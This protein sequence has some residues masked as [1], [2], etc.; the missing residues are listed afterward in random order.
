[1]KLTKL[2]VFCI[3]SLLFSVIAVAQDV[4]VNGIIKDESGMPV[5]GATILL[6]GTTKSTASDFD[7]K[8]QIQVPSNGSLIVTFIGYATVTEAINGR[9]KLTIQLKP[10]SQSLNEVVVVGYGTQK[11]SV[12]TGA[13]SSVKASDLE[14]LPITRVE[15]SLQGRVSGVTIAANAGQPGSSSTIRVRGI[16]SF[17]NNEPLWVVDG[18]IVDSGGIGYLN[19]SDIASMEVLKDAASQAIYGARAAAGVILITTKKGKS[20]KMSVNYN[21]YTGFSAAARKLDLLNA[22]EYATIMNERYANGYTDTSKPY[23]LPYKNVSSYGAGTDWQ[24]QIF[25]DNA[26]RTGHELS[27]SGGN[28]VSTFYVSFGLLDQEGIVASP[29]SNYNRKNIRLNSTH[30]IVKGLTFGQTLGYSHEKTVGIGN[31]NNEYGGP[32]SSAINL[33]PITP[34][35]VTD[36]TVAAAYPYNQNYVLRDPNGNPYGISQ[37]VTQEMSNPL[38]YIQTRL[39]NYNWAD[40]FV[41]NAYLELEAIKGLKIRSTLGGKLAYWGSESFTPQYY[42]NSSTINAKNNLSRSSNRGFGWNIENT[43][44][45]AKQIEDHN[46]SVLV[47]Q[48]AYVDNITSGSTVTY[49][50]VPYTNFDDATFPNGHPQDDIT[51]SA[52]NG[53]EHKVTSL[54]ARANYDY[55]EKYLFTG[56][57][58]RDGSSRFGQNYKYGTFPSFSLGWVPTKESFWPENKVVTQ[59]KF[60]GGYGITGSD[61]IGDFKYLATIGSGRNYTIGDQGSVVVGN[62]PNA[63]A[64]PDLKWEETSQANVAFDITLFNDLSLTTDFYVKKSKGILQDIDLPGHVGST[65]RPSANIADMENKGVDVELSYRKKIGKVGFSVSGNISYLENEVTNLGKNIQF[66]SG[67]ASFQ[68]MGA[69][70]RTQ[71]G[72]S[73][74]SFYGYK[75]QG[76]FQNQAEINAYTNASGGLI[77][78]NARPGDFRWQDLNGDGK[79]SDDDKTFIGSPLPKYTYGLTINLDYKNF[80]L[81][82]FTQGA[83]GNKIFQG[84]RRLDITDANYQ[85]SA[86]GR[87][88]GEGST[89]SYP[90]L[91]TVDNNKNFS[92]PSDFYLEDG[93]YCRIKTI[94]I[95]YNIPADVVAKAGLS[96]TRLYLTGENLLTFT[97]YSGYDP[98]IGGG[99]LGI[100]KG[101]YP[102]ARTIMVGVNLQF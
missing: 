93:D 37:V 59:L 43:I 97:K 32:L 74:N 12:V 85:T 7:G 55:K 98:E 35:I 18:V 15:Q 45:Y 42:F 28:D 79:I 44:S 6:K 51:A 63:P 66:I 29:I 101:Y 89:N 61:A 2:L 50:N 47:G 11:K 70:T 9:T 76:I 69:V 13:I 68:N 5:P 49:F 80:D 86:L 4:T 71:V 65:G 26:Q 88:T 96:K 62:S 54:F 22:T 8:F 83:I 48:G 72:Q 30:K 41:G 1:M 73:Y 33:D 64:N 82:I 14:D 90:I 21:G 102:Q 92:N 67:D 38:A 3:S 57:V 19:Q 25:N 81:L 77:Q 53:Y 31:T 60:R 20:G 36:P 99:V 34:A 56:I 87:W 100:D 39:G 23:D 10:E 24:K 40:N 75:T 46:F 94:Q 17:G 95:G 91:S 52:Y 58:R 27:L 16:T 84:L 78:P